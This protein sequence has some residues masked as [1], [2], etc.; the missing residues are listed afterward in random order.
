[1]E[2][3]LIILHLVESGRNSYTL[4]HNNSILKILL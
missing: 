2:L 3:K 4:V 1:L